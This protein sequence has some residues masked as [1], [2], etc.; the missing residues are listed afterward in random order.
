VRI[1]VPLG[2]EPGQERAKGAPGDQSDAAGAGTGVAGTAGAGTA[3]VGKVA[4]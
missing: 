1:P 2:G 3:G 4:S